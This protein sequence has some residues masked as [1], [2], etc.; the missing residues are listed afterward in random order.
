M[1]GRCVVKGKEIV[2]EE[3]PAFCAVALAGLGNLPDTILT[4]SVIIKMRRRAPGETVEPYRRRIHAPEGY[5]LRDRLAAW[6]RQV[7]DFLDT[8]PDM[9]DGITDRNADVWEALLAVADA[10]GGPWPNL[11]RI[12]AVALVADAKGGSPS[13]GVRLLTDLR[14]IFQD[15]EAVPTAEILSALIEMD[16]APWGDLKGKALDSRRLANLLNPYGVK[17]KN[18]RIAT[19]ITKGYTRESL[20]DAWERYLPAVDASHI[21]SA[22]C[23]PDDESF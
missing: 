22:T 3:L 16:E 1:A 19:A 5:A 15:K 7:R 10:G 13:L 2:T 20:W 9:P 8:C 4:R 17:S 12:A 14:T 21:E 23:V 18:V 11:S 6:A